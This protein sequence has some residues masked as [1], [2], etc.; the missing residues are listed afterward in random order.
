MKLLQYLFAAAL[1]LD[2]CFL[3]G[4]SNPDRVYSKVTGTVTM[5]GAPVDGCILT[6]F[7]Q[8]SDGEGGSG[9]TDA[10][11][12]FVVTSQNAENGGTGLKPGEYK[13][14]VM[15][16]ADFIDEDEDAYNNGEIT[17]D[18]LQERRAKKD[19]YAKAKGGNFLRRRST[20]TRSRRP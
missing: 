18:E 4:C 12:A 8:S 20:A 14:T 19:P 15:K 6:F 10:Q 3:S 7:P 16:N 11:G 1:V 2:L 13:V 17:Y 5:D 9:K